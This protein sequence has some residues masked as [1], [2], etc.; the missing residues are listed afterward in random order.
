MER[1]H[2]FT[3]PDR[4]TIERNRRIQMKALCSQLDSLLPDPPTSREGA[5]LPLPDRLEEAANYIKSLQRRLERMKERKRKLMESEG[6][7]RGT[8]S[9]E[10]GGMRLPQIEVQDLGSGLRVVITNSPGDRRM[11]YEA[12]RVMEEEGGEI[13]NA[14]FLV[15]GDKAFH[16]IH[17]MV[18][19][20]RGGSEAS[21][22]LERLKKACHQ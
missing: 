5:T 20:P 12:V 11:F 14:N 21:K 10:R 16:S 1:S 19:D 22:V 7:S 8:G 3:R 2:G 6:T 17:S 18:A 9:V 4:K 15:V 13:L